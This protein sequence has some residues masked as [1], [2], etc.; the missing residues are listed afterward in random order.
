MKKNFQQAFVLFKRSLPA[1]SINRSMEH[2][3]SDK[4]LKSYK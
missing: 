2:F 3:E 1:K 4:V